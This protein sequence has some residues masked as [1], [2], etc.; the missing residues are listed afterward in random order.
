MSLDD[1]PGREPLGPRTVIERPPPGLARGK[2]PVP[3]WVVLAL[4]ATVVLVGV[5][6]FVRRLLRRGKP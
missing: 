4:G 3:A 2:Y 1:Q 5:A 6:Y